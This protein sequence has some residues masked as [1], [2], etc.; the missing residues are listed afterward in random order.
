MVNN[1]SRKVNRNDSFFAELWRN[2]FLCRLFALII[3]LAA[4]VFSMLNR[5]RMPVIP[6]LVKEQN[7]AY[8]VYAAFDFSYENKIQT[9][10]SKAAALARLPLFYRIDG[11][12]PS[13]VTD[14]VTAF[15]KEAAIRQKALSQNLPYIPPDSPAGR[16]AS[17]LS[18]NELAEIISLSE[19]GDLM[20]KLREQ[21]L[22]AVDNGLIPVYDKEN[23][24]WT[25]LVRIIDIFNR[26]RESRQ[27]KDVPTVSDAA[28]RIASLLLASYP[29]K[30]RRELAKSLTVVLNSILAEGQ[31]ISDKAET[32]KREKEALASVSPIM[33][34]ILKGQPIIAKDAVVTEAD[35]H[36]LNAY[37]KEARARLNDL[38][39][40]SLPMRIV[41]SSAICILILLFSG[42]Y[43]YH[44]H[45]DVLTNNS[46]IRMLSFVTVVSIGS[47]MLAS[48]VFQVFGE[49]YSIPPWLSYIALPLGF[50]PMV[51]SSVYGM[52]C[53]LFT[54][55][56]VTVIAALSDTD[57]FHVV[58]MGLMVSGLAA[59]SV[60]RSLN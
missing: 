7:A 60:R 17:S 56:F 16:L 47:N 29:P 19:S 5:E 34:E 28:S 15:F 59:F 8:T 43:L 58:L 39:S 31:M 45:K 6:H 2:P 27:L 50:A 23:I 54:G 55:L 24:P 36:R 1:S 12:A 33:A 44:I 22:A 53:A 9:D 4:S 38:R 10:K 18:R 46:V 49:L 20:R 40:V 14:A 32:E 11:K 57:A 21:A 3:V 51:L 35:I 37:S 13:K 48:H 52:R 26:V 42:I 25:K 41:K 30:N